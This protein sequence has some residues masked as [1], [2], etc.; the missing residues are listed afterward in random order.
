MCAVVANPIPTS[1]VY[2][3][4]LMPAPD[5]KA[6]K[7]TSVNT[8]D[9]LHPSEESS[10]SQTDSLQSRESGA[11]EDDEQSQTFVP[12]AESTESYENPFLKPAK[13]V[14]LTVL[15]RPS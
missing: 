8:S 13:R 11:M 2:L 5:D 12:E 14:K 4:A 6:D 15:M 7:T 3:Q 10:Q 9:E 1:P